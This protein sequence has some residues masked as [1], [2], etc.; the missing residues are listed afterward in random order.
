MVQGVY[1]GVTTCELDELA[2]QTAAYMATQHREYEPWSLEWNHD[3]ETRPDVLPISLVAVASCWACHRQDR[4]LVPC[5]AWPRVLL[6]RKEPEHHGSPV[7]ILFMS[8]QGK[9]IEG[10]NRTPLFPSRGYPL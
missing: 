6:A 10:I 4:R 5:S 8:Q 3:Q 1:P 7:V 9:V 2:A